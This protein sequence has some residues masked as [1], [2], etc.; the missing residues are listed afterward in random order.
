MVKGVFVKIF[1]IFFTLKCGLSDRTSPNFVYILTDDQDLMLN[2]L[3]SFYIELT[4][5]IRCPI[6][7]LLDV[8]EKIF[9]SYC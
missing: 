7:Y 4:Y 1:I 5:F 6:G 2:G 9:K 8:Y 3:V